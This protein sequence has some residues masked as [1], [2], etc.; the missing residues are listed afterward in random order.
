[1]KHLGEAA[2]GHDGLEDQLDDVVVRML[3]YPT[4][5]PANARFGEDGAAPIGGALDIAL[6]AALLIVLLAVIALVLLLAA[7][8][9]DP[10]APRGPLPWPW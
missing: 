10:S 2:V 4:M 8:A 5:R 6:A 3:R 7:W 1:M 9:H